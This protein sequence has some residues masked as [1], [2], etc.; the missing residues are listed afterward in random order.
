M[1]FE[2]NLF[3]SDHSGTWICFF[4]KD[5]LKNP[6]DFSRPLKSAQFH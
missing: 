1:Q 5:R 6:S 4:G 2:S 3:H